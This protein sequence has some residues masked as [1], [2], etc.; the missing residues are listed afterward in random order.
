MIYGLGCLIWYNRMSLWVDEETLTQ[1]GQAL[2]WSQVSGSGVCWSHWTVCLRDASG[3]SEKGWS[4]ARR[5]SECL[6]HGC[7][8]VPGPPLHSGAPGS[9]SDTHRYAVG[10][11][12]HGSGMGAGS[13]LRR[14]STESDHVV[15][16]SHSSMP[17]IQPHPVQKKDVVEMIVLDFNNGV[18]SELNQ[19]KGH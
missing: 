18:H 9:L 14:E 1:S 17:P 8:P 10:C 19:S 13:Q 5:A 2:W 12:S 4:R 11:R 15:I 16:R 7:T 6:A 3:L